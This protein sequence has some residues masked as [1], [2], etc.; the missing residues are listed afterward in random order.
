M[1]IVLRLL[2]IL[3]VLGIAFGAFKYQRSKDIRWLRMIK[4]ILFC[5]LGLLVVFFIGLVIERLYF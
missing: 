2:F 3:A 4:W 1:F 5:T